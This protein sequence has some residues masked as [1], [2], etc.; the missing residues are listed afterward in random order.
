[1]W[2]SVRGGKESTQWDDSGD[3]ASIM[4]RDRTLRS[5]SIDLDTWWIDRE[6]LDEAV[7][8]LFQMKSTNNEPTVIIEFSVEFGRTFINQL[9]ANAKK[10]FS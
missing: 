1:M 2:P 8:F 4:Q 5:E 10:K 7:D 9:V 3:E 6:P